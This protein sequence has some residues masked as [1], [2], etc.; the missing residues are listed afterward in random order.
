MTAHRGIALVIV[1]IALAMCSALGLGLVLTTTSDRLAA[2]NY[3]E[4]VHAA[5]AADAA[6]QMAARELNLIADW[7]TVLAGSV[8]SRFFEGTPPV[9]LA[10]M[11]NELTCGQAT[12]CTDLRRR[13][14][15][16][17]RPWGANNPVWQVFLRAPLG[18]FLNL[19]GVSADT[20]IV[21]WVGDDARETDDDPRR[22]GSPATGGSVV[23]VRAEAFGPN[24]GRH[25]IEADVIR[26]GTGIRVQSWR[27][28]AGVI[29]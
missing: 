18:K 29:S 2:A 6:L 28:R 4:S 12:D 9:D 21:V 5:N 1:L 26:H 27:V 16:A 22:D 14:S 3:E 20:Y 11:T 23:R 17:E 13:A 19:R 15:T 10:S 7:N 24:G 25:A 8:Q